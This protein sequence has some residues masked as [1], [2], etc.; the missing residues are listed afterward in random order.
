LLDRLDDLAVAGVP[1]DAFGADF[2]RARL[3]DGAGKDGGAHGLLKRH[4][5]AG[6]ARLINERMTGNHSAVHGDAAAWIH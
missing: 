3:V 2:Q 5:L 4:R 1:A 6:D